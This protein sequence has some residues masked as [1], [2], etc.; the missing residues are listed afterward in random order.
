MDDRS[1]DGSNTRILNFVKFGDGFHASSVSDCCCALNFSLMT[2]FDRYLTGSFRCLLFGVATCSG[3]QD[4][5]TAVS[6]LSVAARDRLDKHLKAASTK[7]FRYPQADQGILS[8]D[9]IAHVVQSHLEEMEPGWAQNPE[10]A[11]QVA[12]HT[13]ESLE[14]FLTSARK[15]FFRNISLFHD[16]RARPL[17]EEWLRLASEGELDCS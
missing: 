11:A 15:F 6:T 8:R 4:R 13:A 14:F 17:P 7:M 3:L 5:C 12:S 10:G 16:I 9:D 1:A 2:L